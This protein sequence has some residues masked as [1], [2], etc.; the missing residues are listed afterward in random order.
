M[1]DNE[2]W[3]EPTNALRITIIANIRIDELVTWSAV[4]ALHNI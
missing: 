4:I 2:L 1:S 3:I